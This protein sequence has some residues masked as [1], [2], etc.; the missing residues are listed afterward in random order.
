M[1]WVRDRTG[2]FEW[3]PFYEHREIDVPCEEVVIRFLLERG[4]FV[5]GPLSTDDLTVLIEQDVS[6]LDVCRPSAKMGHIRA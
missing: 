2:R 5:D 3:R 6:D 1:K 4:S